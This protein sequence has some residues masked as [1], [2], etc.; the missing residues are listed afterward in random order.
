MIL[1]ELIQSAQPPRRRHKAFSRRLRFRM[2]ESKRFIKAQLRKVR[3]KT[4][5]AIRRQYFISQAYSDSRTAIKLNEDIYI[6]MLMATAVVGFA[7]SVLMSEIAILFFQTAYDFAEATGVNMMLITSVAVGV[8]LTLSAW[9]LALFLN[10]LSIT[11]IEGANRKFYRSVRSTFRRALSQAPHTAAMWLLVVLMIIVPISIVAGLAALYFY[12]YPATVDQILV[13]APYASIAALIWIVT[14]LINY[15]LAPHVSLFESNATIKQSF[16][17]SRQ[18]VMRKGRVF[19][20]FYYILL[21]SLIAG[22]YTLAKIAAEFGIPFVMIFA[23]LSLIILLQANNVL[24]S[25][26]RK[27]YLARKY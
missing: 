19:L 12:F 5:A 4:N 23:P 14:V 17:R 1:T 6:T 20:L 25:F 3:S 15:G 24:V 8:L 22:A 16:Q 18:L 27:R 9:V 11:T 21:S 7:F 26:Y 13:L 10:S 2:L